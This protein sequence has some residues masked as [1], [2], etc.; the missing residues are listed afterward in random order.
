MWEIE[1]QSKKVQFAGCSGCRLRGP[2]AS[3]AGD[4]SCK[5]LALL[6]QRLALRVQA[7][8]QGLQ[9]LALVLQQSHG[10]RVAAFGFSLL[11]VANHGALVAGLHH[12]GDAVVDDADL[13]G[14]YEDLGE[15]GCECN[16]DQFSVSR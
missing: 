6:L 14:T 1:A 7:S 9:R 11:P 8:D 10:L 15:E 16:V 5:G 13:S 4:E 3:G 12:A 2:A